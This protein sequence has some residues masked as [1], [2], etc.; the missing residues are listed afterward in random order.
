M[1][2]DASSVLSLFY[3]FTPLSFSLLFFY[4]SVLSRFYSFTLLSISSSSLLF[5]SSILLLFCSFFHASISLLF[6]PFP[7]LALYFTLRFFTLPFLLFYPFALLGFFLFSLL[8]IILRCRS[9]IGSCSTQ[10]PLTKLKPSFSRSSAPLVPE[11]K[12][13]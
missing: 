4:S 2:S 9:Y 3:I 5:Y 10:L 11:K 13:E 1:K 8:F 6:Y 12:I 7:A